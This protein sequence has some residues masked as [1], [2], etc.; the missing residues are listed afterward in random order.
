MKR[1]FSG[2][3]AGAVLLAGVATAQVR[4]DQL[5][6]RQDHPSEYVVVKGDTLWDISGR[7]LE[8][9]WLWPE[10]WG[11]NPQIDNPHLI[12]PGDRIYLTWVDGRPRLSLRPGEVRLSPRVRELPLDQAIPAIPLR[13][14]KSF[15]N[16][17]LVVEEDIL[18]RA[19][20]VVGGENRRIISGAGDRVYGRGELIRDDRH[21]AIYRP[22][23]EYHDPETGEFLGYELYKV[24][25]VRILGVQNDIITLHINKSNEEVRSTYRIVPT[26]ESRIQSVFHPQ[27]APLDMDGHIIDVLKGVAKIGQFDAVVINRGQ[28]DGLEPGHVLAVYSKGESLRD[29]ITNET[30]QL[31]SEHA[32]VMMLFRTFDKVS[33]GLIM[34]ATNVI[35]VGDEVRAP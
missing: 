21:Q 11:V 20:Y 18:S 16:D 7:F 34:R 24:A 2:L 32:G 9:P 5:Q 17:N 33:Y 15:I 6:L 31:P 13:D 4:E 8:K 35:T 27:P 25:D 3:L 29:P 22:A 10:I 1:L 28:R 30:I 23:K 26:E 19:P 12:Y 14:I